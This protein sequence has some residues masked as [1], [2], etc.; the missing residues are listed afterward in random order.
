MESIPAASEE[1]TGRASKEQKKPIA[2]RLVEMAKG[3]YRFGRT[4]DGQP[5]A[6]LLAGAN[7]AIPLT[8]RAFRSDLASAY[9]ARFKTVPNSSAMSDA[10]AVLEG[11]ALSQDP[12]AVELRVGRLPEGD[13]V[14]DLGVGSRA[15]VVNA[16]G[17]QVVERSPLLFRRTALTGEIPPPTRGGSL[18][19]LRNLINLDPEDWELAIGWLVASMIP[20]IAHPVVLVDGQQGSGKTSFARVMRSVIDP[21]PC[22]V[23]SEPRDADGWAVTASGVYTIVVDNV[24]RILPWW[25]EALCRCSTGD[26]WVK[27]KLYSDSSLAVLSF[28]RNVMLT[29]IDAGALRGDLADRLL[30]L[31]LVPLN[32]Q[33]RRS[34][35]DLDKRFRRHWPAILGALLDL[36]SQVLRQIESGS[37]PPAL[38]RLA[39]FGRV[40]WAM[41]R[42]LGFPEGKGAFPCFEGQRCLLAEDVI[43][44]DGV[45]NEVRLLAMGGRWTGTMTELGKAIKPDQT[46]KDWPA[47]A[48]ALAGRLARVEPA[49][50]EVGVEVHHR[51]GPAP[52]RERIVEIFLRSD[53]VDGMD[54]S[55]TSKS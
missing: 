14:L 12:E 11:D 45:A 19:A 47:N 38:P 48:R 3:R 9:F 39:D 41:D 23:T 4:A 55:P 16:E 21:S 51:R 52:A 13:I 1:Q 42:A 29:S 24:S 34:E 36:L 10:L 50:R 5:F 37:N 25:S 35:R 7:I 31:R 40:L 22:P 17:W 32:Q 27:R 18:T 28:R 15:V 20:D 44:G 26:G 43:E 8:D 30:K 46:P 49:L 33:S 53:M 6:V 2:D 54:G